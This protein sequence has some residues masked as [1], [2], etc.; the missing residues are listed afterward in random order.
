MMLFARAKAC[1]ELRL[2]AGLDRKKC[3]LD[4]ATL[5]SGC[6]GVTLTNRLLRTTV[7]VNDE[8]PTRMWGFLEWCAR[9]DLNPRPIDP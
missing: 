1:F 7:A 5:L 9:R 2:T 3:V 6:H 4:D 8:S